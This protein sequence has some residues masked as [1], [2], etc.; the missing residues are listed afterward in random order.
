MALQL[1]VGT[2]LI[3][4]C[5]I[6]HALCLEVLLRRVKVSGQKWEL[7]MPVLGHVVIMIIVVLGIFLAHTIEA[8]I[9]AIFYWLAEEN[10]TLSEAVYFSTVTFTTLGFGDITLSEDWRI[11]SS[12]QAVS[13][14]LLFGWSTAFLVN[15][16]AFYWRKHGMSAH[17]PPYLDH[18][19]QSPK[20]K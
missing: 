4:L 2:V 17:I 7:R 5:V 10:E 8:W 14:I 19:E 3:I 18:E 11:T 16:R 1:F 15:V 13:G 20:D 9:W 12:L 6:N